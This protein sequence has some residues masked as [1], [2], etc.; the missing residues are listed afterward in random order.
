VGVLDGSVDVEERAP[1]TASDL[2]ADGRLPGAHEADEDE[3]P[4]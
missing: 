4:V 1:E 3:M 2:L